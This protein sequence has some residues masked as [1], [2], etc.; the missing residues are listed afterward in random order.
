MIENIIDIHSHILFGI[1]DGAKDIKESLEIARSAVRE[2]IIKMVCT[3]HAE[4]DYDGL[5]HN[6]NESIITLR[7]KLKEESIPLA[8]SLGFEVFV[9]QTFLDYPSPEKLAFGENPHILLE[10][11]FDYFPKIFEEVLYLLTISKITPILAHPERYDYLYN[12][13]GFIKNLKQKNVK[14]Q[15][16]T[17]SITGENGSKTQGFAKKILKKGYADFIA[18]DVHSNGLRGPY[19]GQAINTVQN[20]CSP[21]AARMLTYENQ[22]KIFSKTN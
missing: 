16:N 1:D 5:I 15:I 21:Q 14:L 22:M 2:G 12:D 6:A 9:N 8:I 20:W 4:A 10:L 17:A 18:S 3:P 7:Q 19:F 13:L 11:G